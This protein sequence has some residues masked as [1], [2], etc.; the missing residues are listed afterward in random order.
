M[1]RVFERANGD[2][3]IH[4]RDV[5]TA[6]K[7]SLK[8]SIIVKEM[9]PDELPGLKYASLNKSLFE[10]LLKNL[11]LVVGFKVE[12]Y[13]AQRAGKEDWKL[14]FKGSPGNLSQFED[15]LFNSAEPEIL[16]NLLLSISL[17]QKVSN[18]I[19]SHS[20]ENMKTLFILKWF[21]HFLIRRTSAWLQSTP[22]SVSFQSWR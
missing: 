2:Y 10:K 5:D 13:T 3:S 6:L 11:L 20:E 19:P 21:Y 1:F 18:W 14:E 16:N 8:S 12:V 4:G 15:L 7:T 17:H 22:P 9:S